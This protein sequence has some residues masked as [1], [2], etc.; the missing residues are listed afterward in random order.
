MKI[1]VVNVVMVVFLSLLSM[2]S[3]AQQR[4]VGTPEERANRQTARMKEALNLSPD[5]EKNVAA[6]NLKYAQKNQPLLENGGRN[7]KTLRQ[8]RSIMSDK[9]KEMKAAL[10]SDQYKQYEAIK[11][12][13]RNNMRKSRRKL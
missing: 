1:N 12:E 11:E 7:L 10:R 8:V 6:I 5:Q 4:E 13:M 9:D 2:G 3:F